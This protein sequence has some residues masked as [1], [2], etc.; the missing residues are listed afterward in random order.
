MNCGPIEWGQF[1]FY[2]VIPAEVSPQTC[3]IPAESNN[4]NVVPCTAHDIQELKCDSYTYIHYI[5]YVCKQINV[6][7]P[8]WMIGYLTLRWLAIT[9]RTASSD[10]PSLTS[11]WD[12]F[13]FG[14]TMVHIK[15][16]LVCG[17]ETYHL[18]LGSQQDSPWAIILRLQPLVG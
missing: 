13:T 14:D 15:N 9:E 18:S 7:W 16:G 4:G 6:M 10:L 1:Q 3:I 5:I 17:Y 11:C 2:C 12:S 8:H